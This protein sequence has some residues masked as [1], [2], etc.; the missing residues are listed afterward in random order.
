MPRLPQLTQNEV[1]AISGCGGAAM[2]IIVAFVQPKSPV[3][4]IFWSLLLFLFLL[5]PLLI[6]FRNR[7]WRLAT[8]P[9]LCVGDVVFGILIWPSANGDSK[10]SLGTVIESAK[11]TIATYTTQ[12]PW[13]SMLL[14]LSIG[15][16]AT[17]ILIWWFLKHRR[18]AEN[19]KP[20]VQILTPLDTWHVGPR[21]TIRGSVFPSEISK[22]QL[23]VRPWNEAWYLHNEI[24]VNGSAWACNYRLEKPGISYEIVAVY[25]NSLKN[26]QYDELPPRV[27]K[28]NVVKIHQRPNVEELIDCPDQQLHQ[29]KIADK[30]QIGHLVIVCAVR[31]QKVQEGHAPAHIE[32]VFCILNMSLYPMSVESIDGHI[33][34]FIDGEFYPAK[35]LPT[36][37]LKEK[38]S[39]LGFRQPGWFKVQQDFK[40]EGE[41]DLMLNALPDTTL[42]Q[43]NS[44]NVK[45]SGG[46]SSM[47][48]NTSNVSFRKRDNQWNQS[49]EMDF[50]FASMG[51]QKTTIETIKSAHS[52][53]LQKLQFE[54][55][56]L[57]GLNDPD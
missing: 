32:F 6:F 51:D 5:V 50:I 1:A 53:E 23:L 38:A 3:V 39:N 2:A 14:G 37:E 9:V 45:V 31:Y 8:I 17:T 36:L 49:D 46:G 25:G 48:L 44:L 19:E 47:F 55:D 57:K 29:T 33:T 4:T 7:W 30:D 20:R 41:A 43:F 26:P 21:L 13:R 27:V 16:A 10:P 34:Y 56:N 11:H 52:T 18:A 42:F 24:Q 35:L 22:V 12:L 28:S 54:L 40:T 15:V